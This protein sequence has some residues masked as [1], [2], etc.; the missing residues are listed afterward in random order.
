M[1]NLIDRTAVSRVIHQ[2]GA[3]VKLVSTTV[4]SFEVVPL[5]PSVTSEKCELTWELVMQCKTPRI[6]EL[7]VLE[8]LD[9]ARRV[10]YVRKLVSADGASSPAT[11][12][13][14]QVSLEA[15]STTAAIA[16]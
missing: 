7:V 2:D 5:S 16:V 6:I 4:L 3:K 15:F 11:F 12:E 1:S 8:V 9:T 14:A 13:A 10:P